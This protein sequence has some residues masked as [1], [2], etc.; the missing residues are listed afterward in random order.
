MLRQRLFEEKERWDGVLTS[1]PG[2]EGLNT[3]LCH[4]VNYSAIYI[5]GLRDMIANHFV[6]KANGAERW[7]AFKKFVE[8]A[9]V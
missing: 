9:M 6:E 1:L 7:E 2:I 5:E 8:G 3:K 4:F